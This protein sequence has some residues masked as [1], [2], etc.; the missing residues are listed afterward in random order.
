M[1]EESDTESTDAKSDTSNQPKIKKSSAKK[2]L[3]LDDSTANEEETEDDDDEAEDNSEEEEDEDDEADE[4]QESTAEE[5]HNDSD[6]EVKQELI[7]EILNFF[8]KLQIIMEPNFLYLL[9]YEFLLRF[10]T[11]FILKIIKY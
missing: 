10:L 2:A 7:I 8:I 3:N 6:Y 1:E 11:I 4:T 9:F 5:D